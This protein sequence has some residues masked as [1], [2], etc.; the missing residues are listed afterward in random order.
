MSRDDS[1]LYAGSSSMAFT[2]KEQEVVKKRRDINHEKKQQ[3]QPA[4]E[5]VFQEI[6][7]EKKAV[8]YIKN[9]DVSN[10]S[11]E[12]MFMIEMMARRKYVDYLDQLKLKLTIVLREKK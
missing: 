10:A 7:N 8:M 1:M 9:I 2:H 6:E 3:L 4:A 5:V 11:D 12:K